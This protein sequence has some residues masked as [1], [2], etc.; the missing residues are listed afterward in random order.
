MSLTCILTTAPYAST[1]TPNPENSL[2]PI[3]PQCAFYF[4]QNLESKLSVFSKIKN[5]DKSGF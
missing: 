3:A 4:F 2:K 1:L 5:P